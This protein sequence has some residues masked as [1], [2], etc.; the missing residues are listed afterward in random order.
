MDFIL[1]SPSFHD[2]SQPSCSSKR[3]EHLHRLHIALM[4]SVPTMSCHD[5]ANLIFN[6]IMLH[7]LLQIEQ[8]LNENSISRLLV[9]HQ[10]SHVP[11]KL[12][13]LDQLKPRLW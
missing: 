1:I 11:Q 13:F 4:S 10:Y 2:D 5:G 7:K 8:Y 3:Q 9:S 12:H 6:I